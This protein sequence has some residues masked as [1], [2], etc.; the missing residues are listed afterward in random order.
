M[1]KTPFVRM[2]H[3]R[4]SPGHGRLYPLLFLQ[5]SFLKEPQ[6]YLGH[7]PTPGAGSRG[8]SSLR[9]CSGPLGLSPWQAQERR[10]DSLS[11][12][13]VT[14]PCPWLSCTFPTGV[15][16]SALQTEP[17]SP[18]SPRGPGPPS[19]PGP[20]ERSPQPSPPGWL[21]GGFSSHCGVTAWQTHSSGYPRRPGVLGWAGVQGRGDSLLRLRGQ[22]ARELG[23]GQVWVWGDQLMTFAHNSLVLA[24]KP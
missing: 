6:C 1:W 22:Q 7:T 23:L 19:W 18:A 5:P 10:S 15:P 17:P 24:L 13:L 2:V 16:G 4:C 21:S 12:F 3:P 9:P 8:P 20:G 14:I 11:L